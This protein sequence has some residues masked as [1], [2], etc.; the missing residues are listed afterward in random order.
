MYLDTSTA[1]IEIK[2]EMLRLQI[3]IDL[4]ILVLQIEMYDTLIKEYLIG[5]A[6]LVS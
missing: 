5:C 1:K 3:P 2:G 6:R 4:H